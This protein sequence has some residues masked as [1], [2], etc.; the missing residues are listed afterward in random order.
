MCDYKVVCEI[1]FFSNIFLLF[2]EFEILYTNSKL[3]TIKVFYKKMLVV[4]LLGESHNVR[5]SS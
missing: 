4:S 2:N 1:T 5:G 3:F